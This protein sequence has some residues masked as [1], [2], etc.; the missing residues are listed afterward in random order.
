MRPPGSSP[1]PRARCRARPARALCFVGSK[2]NATRHTIRDARTHRMA[3]HENGCT[4]QRILHTDYFSN[5]VLKQLS[6]K[7][8]RAFSSTSRASKKATAPHLSEAKRRNVRSRSARGRVYAAVVHLTHANI[9]ERILKVCINARPGLATS[10]TH[11]HYVVG[12][13]KRVGAAHMLECGTHTPRPISIF[14][15]D[16]ELRVALVDRPNAMCV[17]LTRLQTDS[18]LCK[19]DAAKN[20]GQ[21]FTF[22]FDLNLAK[23]ATAFSLPVHFPVVL[24]AVRPDIYACN[25]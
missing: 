6:P 23:P 21:T 14:I 22:E 18:M 3:L 13:F 11:N 19:L 12:P 4:I 10:P 17:R 2:K 24:R 1:C 20:G 8:L 15:L 5:C 16:Q 7:S 25:T 9:L